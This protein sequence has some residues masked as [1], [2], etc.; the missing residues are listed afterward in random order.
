MRLSLISGDIAGAGPTGSEL[1]TCRSTR[2]YCAASGKQRI[3]DIGVAECHGRQRPI[4][5]KTTTVV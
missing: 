4:S 1:Q 2:T 3:T 5:T